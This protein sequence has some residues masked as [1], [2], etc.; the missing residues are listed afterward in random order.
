MRIDGIGTPA[1]VQGAIANSASTDQ[2]FKALLD[3]AVASK[4]DKQLKEASKQFE[5][6]F[7]YQ[8]FSKMRETVAQGGLFDQD[9]G[10]FQQ[11]MEEEIFQGML[12]QEISVKATETG[13]IGLADMIYKQLINK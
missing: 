13:G 6:L 7:I 10:M 12:D 1:A 11:D 8:M 3:K 5:A 4:E 9:D 2:G